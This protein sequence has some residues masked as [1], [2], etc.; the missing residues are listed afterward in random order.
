M[1]D[2]RASAKPRAETVIPHSKAGA[3][4]HK[5]MHQGSTPTTRAHLR[6][7]LQLGLLKRALRVRCIS[8]PTGSHRAMGATGLRR[9]RGRSWAG[10]FGLLLN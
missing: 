4:G 9:G 8:S 5:K 6:F 2:E 3:G 7:E 1:T 10:A